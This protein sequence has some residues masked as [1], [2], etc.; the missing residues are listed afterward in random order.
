MQLEKIYLQLSETQSFETD[1]SQRELIR[2][3]ESYK[4]AIEG[5]KEKGVIAR[6]IERLYIS[7]PKLRHFGVYI[8]GGVGRGKTMLMEL[9]YNNL[10]HQKKIK[11]HFHEMMISIHKQLDEM[12]CRYKYSHRSPDYINELAKELASKYKVLCL[13]ELQINN[14]AD[15]MVVGRLFK[16]LFEQE[17]FVFFTSNRPPDELFKDGLQRE[18]FLPFIDLINN[19]LDVFQLNNFCDYRLSNVFKIKQNYITPLNKD[20]EEKINEIIFELTGRGELLSREIQIDQNRSISVMHCYGN[21]AVF[22]FKE[23]CE[24]PLGAIDYLA[25]CNNFNTLIIKNIPLLTPDHH[26]EILRFITLVDC[27]YEKKTRLI[28]SATNTPEML[29][30]GGKNQFEFQ[31]TISRL[32]EMQTQEYFHKQNYEQAA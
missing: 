4:N 5:Q 21:V 28:C 29:Y 17:V 20:T 27:M 24:I 15:A 26:N 7:K 19:K 9:F 16:A 6:L 31:R 8:W 22:T 2:K 12:R 25:L 10:Q 32:K 13:D 30:E 3:L 1:S 14:I 23:L 18:H 11:I